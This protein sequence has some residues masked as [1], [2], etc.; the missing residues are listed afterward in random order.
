MIDIDESVHLEMIDSAEYARRLRTIVRVD[1]TGNVDGR[2]ETQPF[3]ASP[4]ILTRLQSTA[5]QLQ[6]YHTRDRNAG[7]RIRNRRRVAAV[8]RQ[9]T[10]TVAV[11]S[12][13]EQLLLGA[14]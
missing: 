14:H 3:R 2:R 5:S 13:Q 8:F 6:T 4:F 11:Y 7:A 10:D 9:V 1:T 12:L